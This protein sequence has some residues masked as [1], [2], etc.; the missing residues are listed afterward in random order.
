MNQRFVSVLIF[1]FVVAAGA[2]LLL[3]RMLAHRVETAPAPLAQQVIVAARNLDP[4]TLVKEQDLNSGPWSGPLPAA[5]SRRTET[6]FQE[7]SQ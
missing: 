6:K 4:G 5:G 2:S 3:Y 7:S 1:A